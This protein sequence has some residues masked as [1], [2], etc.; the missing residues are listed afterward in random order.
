MSGNISDWRRAHAE[1][2]RIAVE[3]VALD[4]DEGQWL[5][6]AQRARV[7]RRLGF[8]T[9]AE[10]VERVLGYG[11]RTTDDK[12]RVAAALE[13]LPEL[14]ASEL[15]WSALREL[16]RV[17][18]PATEREWVAAAEG[19]TVR[20]LERL[21][22]GR[23]PGDRPSDPARD[24]AR[25]HVL[26]FDVSADTVATVREA[27]KMLRRG[28]DEPL[29]DDAALLLMARAVLGGPGDA[30]RASY[31]IAMTV[32]ERCQHATQQ[33]KGE[34]IAV[35]PAIAEM[36]ACDAQYVAPG[37]RATQAVPPATRREVVR[38]DGGCCAVPG[39]KNAV[40]VDLHHV[41]PRAEGGRHD[42]ARMVTL[43]SAHHRLHHRGRLLVEGDA[44]VG[45]TFRHA[46]GSPYGRVGSVKV[47]DTAA[48][49]FTALRKLG[50]K[51]GEARRAIKKARAH[52][53]DGDGDGDGDGV[54]A[55]LRA[56]LGVLSAGSQAA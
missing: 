50:F 7:H 34:A 35:E 4:R 9:F 2:L 38:R 41:D 11:P 12:L 6:A 8:A 5:L 53:G 47:A 28:S 27:L 30:G 20:E 25:R 45:F 17:A 32:C 44:H 29:D 56:A 31:Q 1:L 43:C 54:E 33:G 19:R 24:E 23:R 14:A 26:R 39:C 3:R 40:F 49:V 37:G 51:E 13:E 15:S 55:L 42:P 46:D 52:V 18:T 48:R 16:T 21:V 10:Y 36:A 22:S